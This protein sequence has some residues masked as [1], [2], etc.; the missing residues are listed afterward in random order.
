M[1]RRHKKII[2]SSQKLP[3]TQALRVSALLLASVLILVLITVTAYQLAYH[4]KIYPGVKIA[5]MAVGN[6]TP[7][8]AQRLLERR[9]ATLHQA[10]VSFSLEKEVNHYSLADLDVNFDL[11]FAVQNAY[12]LGRDPNLLQATKDRF[13]A[14]IKSFDLTPQPSF[15]YSRLE[16]AVAYY[17]QKYG[18][19][20]HDAQIK[21]TETGLTISPE[22]DGK[23]VNFITAYENFLSTLKTFSPSPIVL[24][25]ETLKPQ[26]TQADLTPLQTKVETLLKTPIKLT[27][28]N[29]SFE[30]TKE[31]LLSMISFSKETGVFLDLK[32]NNQPV[33]RLDLHFAKEN[34]DKPVRLTLGQEQASSYLQTLSKQINRE[35]VN[36]KFNFDQ[37]R[38]AAFTPHQNGQKLD[39]TD[40][41]KQL[42]SLLETPKETLA[43]KVAV[44]EAVVTT[45]SIN[46]YGIK[47][48]IGSGTSRFAGSIP[49]RQENVALAANRINGTLVAP[50]EVFSMYRTIGEVDASTGYREAYIISSGK[51]QLDF[52]GGVCQVSTTIFRAALNSGLPIVERHP[53]AYRVGYYEQNS[54]P[55]IDASVFFPYSDFRFKNDTGHYILIQTRLNRAATTLTFEFYGTKD[56]REVALTKPVVT[57]HTPPPP[58]LHQD[59]PTLPKGVVKQVDFS[60]A[61]ASTNFT[62]TVTR[63]GEVLAKD[64]FFSKYRPWQAIFLHGTKE[65]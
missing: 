14:W 52:G 56:G 10:G 59:D 31:E 7:A 12:S 34:P 19:E 5:G 38:V 55:G 44:T 40:T 27:F 65:S 47:E 48:L 37:G 17:D 64:S 43:L 2:H 41:L 58:D 51:T 53:H 16:T 39:E 13:S 26:I 61:G 8:E 23:K 36:A 60:A 28:N 35:P 4:D 63:G 50:G 57:G 32:V 20:P 49:N 22:A 46:N 45:E 29:Q 24:K 25:L 21:L 11:N 1:A 42:Q 62:R 54:G 30:L 33:S 6:K 9:L 15:S 18:Q 3:Q